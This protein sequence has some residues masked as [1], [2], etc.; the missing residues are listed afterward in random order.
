MRRLAALLALAS[1]TPAL[2]PAQDADLEYRRA[3]SSRDPVEAVRHLDLAIQAAPRIEYFAQRARL[4]LELL[5]DRAALEDYTSGLAL[6]APPAARAQMLLD[7]SRLLKGAQAEA[8][9]SEALKLMPGYTE[10][11]LERARLRRRL[12]RPKEADDDLV[13]ARKLGVDRADGYYNE[14]VRAIT[15]GDAAEAERMIGFALDLD[16]GHSRAHVAKARLYMERRL[17]DDAARELDA[18]V[19]VHPNEPDL[20]YYRGTA[21]L[22]AGRAQDALRDF[23]KAAGLEKQAPYI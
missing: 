9:L 6:E 16:P 21:L 13:E 23:E 12:G 1:C 4:H 11:W 20:Y 15:K 10:A 18:A 8:D 17:F 7:R 3:M 2:T 14:A 22:A 19:P 5:Q